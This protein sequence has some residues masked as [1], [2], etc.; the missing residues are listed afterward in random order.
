M[1]YIFYI[2]ILTSYLFAEQRILKISNFID[3]IDV[4]V[5]EN[6]AHENNIKII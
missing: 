5:L 3:Y 1:K 6:F 2:I 4:K